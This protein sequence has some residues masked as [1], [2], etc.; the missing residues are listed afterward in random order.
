[1]EVTESRR[2]FLVTTAIFSL[3]AE[4]MEREHPI[5]LIDGNKLIE[6]IAEARAK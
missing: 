1:M 6:W 4:E 2:G 3:Q 5:E